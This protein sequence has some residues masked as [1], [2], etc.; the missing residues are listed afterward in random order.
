MTLPSPPLTFLA[1][2]VTTERKQIRLIR[3]SGIKFISFLINCAA[4]INIDLDLMLDTT[5]DSMLIRLEP[6]LN[7]YTHVVLSYFT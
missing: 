7:T 1:S 3:V 4:N 2:Y 6:Y 5:H